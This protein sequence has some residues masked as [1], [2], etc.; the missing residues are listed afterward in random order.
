MLNIEILQARYGHLSGADLLRPVLEDRIVGHVAIAS[1]F[2]A[3]SAVLLHM[4]AS[5]DPDVPVIFLDT[6]KLFPETLTY[7]DDLIVRLGLT[8]TR[9]HRPATPEI[10]GMDR[11]GTLHATDPDACCVLRKTRPMER[12]LKGYDGWITGR[13]RFQSADRSTIPA[14]ETKDR[15]IKVNPL[16]SFSPADISHYMQNHDLPAH[17]L[18]ADGYLSIGC[19]PCTTPVAVGEDA[20]A[21]RWRGRAKTECGIHFSRNGAPVRASRAA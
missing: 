6:G 11:H 4:A 13:K 18:V 12:A 21:G 17:P 9:T 15:L 3:E 20:R 5:I 14:F 7:R 8:D 1:S 16:A 2:G 10:N 19:V